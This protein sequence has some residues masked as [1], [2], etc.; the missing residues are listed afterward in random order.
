MVRKRSVSLRQHRRRSFTRRLVGLA[1]KQQSSM[2]ENAPSTVTDKRGSTMIARATTPTTTMAEVTPHL[3]GKDFWLTMMETPL[4]NK[5]SRCHFE[6][7]M[8][9]SPVRYLKYSFI[10]IKFYTSLVHLFLVKLSKAN[11]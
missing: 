10:P 2:E 7:E 1:Q 3:L 11:R 6:L 8:Q 9:S 4:M 5:Q